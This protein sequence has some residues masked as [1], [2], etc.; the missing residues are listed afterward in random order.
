MGNFA[1]PIMKLT[2]LTLLKQIK[3]GNRPA[4]TTLYERYWDDLYR[5]SYVR[6]KDKE[7]TE[8]LLQNL[9]IRVPENPDFV[10]TDETE[11][12]KG[13]LL[14][15][16]H[17]RIIDYYSEIKKAHNL[18]DIEAEGHLIPEMSDSEYF[19]TLEDYDIKEIFEMINQIV[20]QLSSTDQ[21]VYDLRILQ[22]KSVNE[23]AENLN[24]SKKTVSNS[25]SATLSKIREKLDPKYQSSKNLASVIV[26]LE[27]LA[28]LN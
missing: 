26:Y 22:N 19:E 23:T 15:Y 9:W 16:M 7:A 28:N 4:F 20:S 12:A 11:S 13:Y 25:L 27:V 8:E 14:K 6:T 1:V 10:Q 5:M 21:K 17:Y 24:I 3:S 2:D 18:I